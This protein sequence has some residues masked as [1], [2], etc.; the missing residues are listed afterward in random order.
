M[1]LTTLKASTP[2]KWIDK[3]TGEEKT[4]WVTLGVAF[5]NDDKKKYPTIQLDA[6]P[7]PDAEGK[8]TIHLFEFEDDQNL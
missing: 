8:A 7:M 6:L 4:K 2:R 5:L 1:A 3:K